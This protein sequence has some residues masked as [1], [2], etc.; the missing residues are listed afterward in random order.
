MTFNANA[1]IKSIEKLNEKFFKVLLQDEKNQHIVVNVPIVKELD[2]EV[3][4]KVSI[5]GNVSAFNYQSKWYN[6]LFAQTV[7]PENKKFILVKKEVSNESEVSF[8]IIQY[9][10]EPFTNEYIL[11][12][13]KD[14]NKKDAKEVESEVEKLTILRKAL[15]AFGSVEKHLEYLNLEYWHLQNSI[16]KNK[17]RMMDTKIILNENITFFAKAENSPKHTKVFFSESLKW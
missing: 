13:Y 8:L 15:K 3:N 4:S 11:E 14:A 2:L 6:N 5:W 12:N 17:V 16:T 7:V 1:T 9:S 10:I